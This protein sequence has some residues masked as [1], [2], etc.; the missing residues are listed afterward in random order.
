M[1]KH[2]EMLQKTTESKGFMNLYMYMIARN[3]FAKNIIY[4]LPFC[5]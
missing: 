4:T 1:T 5:K 3:G 2:I